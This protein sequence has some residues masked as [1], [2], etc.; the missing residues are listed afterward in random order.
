MD[1]IKKSDAG[2]DK[3]ENLIAYAKKHDAIETKKIYL[4]CV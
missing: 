2:N 1:M 3:I 4:E